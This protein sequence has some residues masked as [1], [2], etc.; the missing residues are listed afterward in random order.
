VVG[1]AE[2]VWTCCGCVGCI[3]GDGYTGLDGKYYT[4]RHSSNGYGGEERIAV[5]VTG[6]V[7]DSV[8]AIRTCTVIERAGEPVTCP[9]PSKPRGDGHGSSTALHTGGVVS[10]GADGGSEEGRAGPVTRAVLIQYHSTTDGPPET[11]WVVEHSD[12]LAN[13]RGG[14]VGAAVTTANRRSYRA[15]KAKALSNLVG[16]PAAV[17]ARNLVLDDFAGM[18]CVAV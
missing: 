9:Q 12:R 11:E 14:A 13:L 2:A 10:E 16:G 7:V 17:D 15:A 3:V 1:K 8:G 4:L 5:G 18:L 6:D